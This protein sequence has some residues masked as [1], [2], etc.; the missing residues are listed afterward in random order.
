MPLYIL[1]AKILTSGKLAKPVM[2]RHLNSN[3]LHGC[4]KMLIKTLKQRFLAGKLRCEDRRGSFDGSLAKYHGKSTENG[5]K[6]AVCEI[7]VSPVCVN[8][9]HS[10]SWRDGSEIASGWDGTPSRFVL[11]VGR[12]SFFFCRSILNSRNSQFIW[13]VFRGIAARISAKWSRNR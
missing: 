8:K 10:W 12:L 1:N 5:R 7:A 6:F 11:V 9:E 3:D 13:F 2:T 4:R